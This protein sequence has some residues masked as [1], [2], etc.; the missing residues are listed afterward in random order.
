MGGKGSSTE[1]W[2]RPT[3][4]ERKHDDTPTSSAQQAPTPWHPAYHTSGRQGDGDTCLL[5]L[6]ASVECS[7]EEGFSSFYIRHKSSVVNVFV[8]DQRIGRT[9]R[10]LEGNI[11]S[12]TT[13]TTAYVN[14][15]ATST[16]ENVVAASY[17]T[18]HPLELDPTL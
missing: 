9:L 10:E 16:A 14:I 12:F 18:R 6:L 1:R 17:D 4:G 15:V 7:F 5:T 8:E 11:G 3:H 2:A 13:T